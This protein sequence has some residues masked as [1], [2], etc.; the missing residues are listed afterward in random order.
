MGGL[1]AVAP[2]PWKK[3]WTF[4]SI[5][6]GEKGISFLKVVK[7]KKMNYGTGNEWKFGTESFYWI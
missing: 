1:A 4:I 3:E 5:Q 6:K 7:S 2:S